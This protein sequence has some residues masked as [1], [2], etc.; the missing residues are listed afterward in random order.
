MKL[1]IND[2]IKVPHHTGRTIDLRVT[3][4]DEDLGVV[5]G[6][7]GSGV[8]HTTSLGEV[9]RIIWQRKNG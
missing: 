4:I 8:L 7:H 2:L 3:H 6:A 1:Q 5:L 9:Q